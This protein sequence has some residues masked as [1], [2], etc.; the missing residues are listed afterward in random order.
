MPQR[1]TRQAWTGSENPI[2]AARKRL[3][4]SRDELGRILRVSGRTISYWERQAKMPDPGRAA[5][6]SATLGL[7]GVDLW[8]ALRRATPRACAKRK[9]PW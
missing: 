5:A 7:S 3:G 1:S 6:L 2:R 9:K 8:Q 4:L